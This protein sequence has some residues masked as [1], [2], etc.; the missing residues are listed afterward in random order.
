MSALVKKQ[1]YDNIKNL[2][3]LQSRTYTRTYADNT[4]DNLQLS[5]S[6]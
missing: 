2:N 1:G 6:H 4:S 3:C 5:Q